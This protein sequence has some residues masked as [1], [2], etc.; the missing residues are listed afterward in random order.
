MTGDAGADRNAWV[1]YEWAVIRI[2]PRVHTE[3]FVNVGVLLHARQQ[4]FLEA[5]LC[6][7]WEERVRGLAPALD[8]DRTRRHLETLVR[9]CDGDDDAGPIALLPPSERFH[10]LTHPRSGIVQTSM[11]HPGRCRSLESAVA[12]LLEE[13]CG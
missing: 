1:A 11:P 4:G 3:Q 7:R 13:Q 5:R 9:I 12:R 8:E 6:E 2:V 10:W